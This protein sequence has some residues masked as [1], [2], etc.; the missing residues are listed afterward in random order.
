MDYTA[1]VPLPLGTVLVL[2]AAAFAVAVAVAAVVVYRGKIRLP[3]PSPAGVVWT[4]AVVYF[5]F[6]AAVAL[7]RHFGM[8]TTGLDLGYY[9]NAIFS[10][11]RGAFFSQTLLPAERYVNHCAPLIAALAPLTYV[12]KDP[13]Y[14]LPVQSLFIAAGIPLVYA[15]G[16]PAAGSKWPAA[17]FAVGF[18]LSPA[19]HGAHLFDFHPRALGVP[20]ALAALYFFSRREFRLGIAFTLLMALA[21]DELALHA[22]GLAA[23]GGIATGRRRWG[24]LAAG[25]FAVYFLGW[26]CVLYPKL[27]Y[28]TDVGPL[29]N[30]FLVRHLEHTRAGAADPE[31]GRLLGEK[32]GYIGALVGPAV[33]AL[34]AAGP[35]L[36]T[37][38][39]PLAVP[40][41]T[42]VAP[43]Y[44]IGC[45]YGLSVVP[46]M[47]GAAAL[48]IRRLVTPAPT[49]R[50][51]ALIIGACV[52]AVAFQLL[53]ITVLAEPYYK[54]RLAQAFP[55]SYEKAL[56]GAVSRVPPDAPICADDPFLAH[57]AHRPYVY[58]S[59]PASDGARVRPEYLLVNRRLHPLGNLPRILETAEGWGLSLAECSGDYAYFSSNPPSRCPEAELFRRWYGNVEEWQV[60]TPRGGS[61]VDDPLAHDGRAVLADNHVFVPGT[62]G[63]LY[64]P[65]RYKL[66]FRLRPAD[67][68]LPGFAMLVASLNTPNESAPPLVRRKKINLSSPERYKPYRLRFVR[69]KPFTAQIQ[70]HAVAPFYFDSITVESADYT[71]AAVRRI[72]AARE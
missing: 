38:I 13:S 55:G 51:R 69:K 64:P 21:H 1:Q 33:A 27:T 31:L 22:V 23:Y 68:G 16:R 36:L 41:I 72:N 12:F 50:R 45:Q 29:Q 65:G 37:L 44:K 42:T 48:A 67:P 60:W 58:L 15:I 40:A 32:A 56:A 9:G 14:L 43:A 25:V 59:G 7:G 61:A 28:A 53:L 18:A 52:A 47:F 34:P 63:Y 39:T 10:T 35:A 6:F 19:L 62:A 46:F 2:A 17:V 71:L 26:C 20:L 8:A 57:L 5:V 49:R 11:G 54:P 66:T 4:L 3:R 24:F 30:R 70:I